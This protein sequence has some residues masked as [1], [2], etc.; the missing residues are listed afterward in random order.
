MAKGLF[1][2]T[3]KVA[4]I[5]GGNSGLGLGFA[6]GIAKQGGSVVIWGRNAERNAAAKKELEALGA[7]VATTQ[8][9][10]ASEEQIIAGYEAVIKQFG[11]VDCVIAN[12]GLPAPRNGTLEQSTKEYLAFIDVSMHGSFYTLREGA[13]QMVK[14]AEAGELGGSLIFCGSLSMFQGLAGKI[15]YAA[16]KAAMGA[17]IRCLAV[18]FGKYG[19]RANSIAPG[20]IKTGMTG[21]AAEINQVDKYFASKTPIPRPGYPADFEGIAAYLCSDASSFLSG[22]TIVID[23]GCLINL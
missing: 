6:R 4:V 5:T 10:V 16:S 7:K 15:S 2:L 8:V 14:R 1:D 18:E 13:R 22:D 20:Y 21:T 23:G 17:A 3:G 11:R 19:I 12:A 9:D